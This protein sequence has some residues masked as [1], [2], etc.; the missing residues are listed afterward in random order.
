MFIGNESPDIVFASL[1]ETLIL[2]DFDSDNIAEELK[3]FP[4]HS[5]SRQFL[6]NFQKELVRIDQLH[7]DDIKLAEDHPIELAAVAQKYRNLL[8]AALYQAM[9]V[10]RRKRGQPVP[11]QRFESNTR[12]DLRQFI[13]NKGLIINELGVN[14]PMRRD[15]I[16]KL[17][18]EELIALIKQQHPGA[19]S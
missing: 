13:Y 5:S 16:D 12:S 17:T 2:G 3:K 18:R 14:R 10:G 7:Y 4:H 6:E 11:V 15:E 8:G 19:F 9:G 1:Q